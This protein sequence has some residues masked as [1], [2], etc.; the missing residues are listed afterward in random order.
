MNFLKSSPV[1]DYF[2]KAQKS[3]KLPS[4]PLVFL[5]SQR[6]GQCRQE[7]SDN[8]CHNPDNNRN[9]QGLEPADR[10]QLLQYQQPDNSRYQCSYQALAYHII[11]DSVQIVP[12]RA[13]RNAVVIPSV[14]P[15]NFVMT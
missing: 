10:L 15:N 8:G 12:M 9:Q 14:S 4:H 6:T 11:D 7:P 1:V 13:A 3:W 2:F 5:I